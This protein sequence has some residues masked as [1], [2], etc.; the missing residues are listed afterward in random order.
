[1][2]M[3]PS[4]LTKNPRRKLAR[5]GVRA[6]VVLSV[7]INAFMM[8]RVLIRGHTINASINGVLVETKGLPS[9]L[10]TD[11][12]GV[13]RLEGHGFP[14]EITRIDRNKIAI[15]FLTLV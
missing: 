8:D 14:C 9:G 10:R 7:L 15:Q 2:R 6:P 13:F 12:E 1:M 4:N 11:M 5:Y 3:S